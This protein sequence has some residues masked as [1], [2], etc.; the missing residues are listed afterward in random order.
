MKALHDILQLIIYQIPHF[1]ATV[2][3]K[4]LEGFSLFKNKKAEIPMIS[5]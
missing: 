2:C 4:F 1:C 5:A 3:T